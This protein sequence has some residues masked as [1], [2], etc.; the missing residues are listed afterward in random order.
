[1]WFRLP[2][3]LVERVIRVALARGI[4]HAALRAVVRVAQHVPHGV[5]AVAYVLVP[6]RAL[7]SPDGGEPPPVRIEGRL[8]DRI[9]VQNIH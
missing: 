5:K 6:R 1:M 4:A 2:R 9:I 8:V 7:R 3:Q